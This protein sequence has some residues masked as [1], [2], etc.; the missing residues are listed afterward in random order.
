MTDSFKSVLIANRGEIAVRI[1]RAC[2]KNALRSVAVYSDA[3]AG[4]L[5]VRLADE[6][7]RVGR[8][9]PDDSYLNGPAMVEL[10][11]A[12]GA[13]AVHPGYGFLAEDADFAQ[14]CQ[15]ARL[16]WIGPSPKAMRLLGNKASA[17]A[18]AERV[19]V[20]TLP[21]YHGEAQDDLT[22]QAEADCIGF[23][24]LVKA[25]A[26]GGGRGMRRVNAPGE[27]NEALAGARREARSA[28]GDNRLLLERYLERPRHVEMQVFGD[29][30]GNVVYLG[31]R[32]CSI[33]RRHQK[34]IEEAPAPHF[35]G[36][37]RRAMGQAAVNLVR[38]GGYTNA[39]T[40]EFLLDQDG[41]FYFLEVNT[42]LQVE[43]PVTEMVTGLDLVDLQFKVAAGEPLPFEQTDLKID[44]H[45]IEARLYAEDPTSGFLPSSG[46]LERF[47][48]PCEA[49][50][51]RVDMGVFSGDVVSPFY[52]PLLAKVIAHGADR[53]SALD[54]IASALSEVSVVGV[55][56]N[57]DLLQDIV[58]ASEFGHGLVHTD[59]LEQQGLANGP[60]HP[61]PEFLMA[62]AVDDALFGRTL[63]DAAGGPWRRAGPWRLGGVGTEVY[64][65]HATGLFRVGFARPLQPDGPWRFE[66]PDG[67]IEERRVC[68]EPP[69][70]SVDGP[71][72]R[73]R[74]CVARDGH[75]RNIHTGRRRARLTLDSGL[76]LA[77][78]QGAAYA[79]GRRDVVGAPMPGRIV[80][81]LVRAGDQVKMNQ[82]LLV[83]EAMK[84]E[85]LV[86]APH[87]GVVEA[88][89]FSE[90]DQVD[91]GAELVVLED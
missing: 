54:R 90:G 55:R 14:L 6:A 68:Y 66:L 42:R 33:Q 39:G 2:Q 21:G 65:R 57:V 29:A 24:L 22:L 40:V 17:K 38:A 83:L 32:D 26:G 72:G 37:Q 67:A 58:A 70:V 34:V 9:P 23:P 53:D 59:F 44:G 47:R 27:L 61:A 64:Y 69:A 13:Q 71:D 75:E 89:R 86:T 36:Q 74:L 45:A 16:V 60:L 50:G 18:L 63:K 11:R 85:H 78:S 79:S 43:H 1:I 81:L 82:T 91:V 62:A 84:I 28:F 87:D 25:A 5:H 20:P 77:G 51:L 10:A 41:R 88:V 12:A 31:E 19:G 46:R 73:H 4:T 15:Q 52:D 3:D 80:K 30:H 8:P 35:S 7:Y 56:T 76:D 48:L 49:E